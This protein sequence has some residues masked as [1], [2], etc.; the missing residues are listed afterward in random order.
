MT[1]PHG[2]KRPVRAAWTIN[3]MSTPATIH[4]IGKPNK[5]RTPSAVPAKAVMWR[6]RAG[7]SNRGPVG[8]STMRGRQWR[9]T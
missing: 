1:K 2:V 7:L 8:P 3:A 9:W 4:P 5:R 6:L